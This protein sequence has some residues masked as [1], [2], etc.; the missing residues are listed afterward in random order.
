MVRTGCS[1]CRGQG[2]IPGWAT[3]IRQATQ[4]G[5]NNNNDEHLFLYL[6][7]I[8]KASFK[9][10]LEPHQQTQNRPGAGGRGDRLPTQGP[11]GL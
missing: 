1:H 4:C 9:R 6:L 10:L 3:K 8:C 7:A 11:G 2:S 5:Q